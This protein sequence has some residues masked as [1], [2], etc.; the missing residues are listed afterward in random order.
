[1]SKKKKN[2]ERKGSI[3]WEVHDYSIVEI[4]NLENKIIIHR[5]PGKL[6]VQLW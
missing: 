4:L 6:A 1:L 3:F 2:C 5:R